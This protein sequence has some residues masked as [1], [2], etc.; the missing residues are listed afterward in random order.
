MKIELWMSIDLRNKICMS[1]SF[2]KNVNETKCER[3]VQSMPRKY[4]ESDSE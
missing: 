1:L 3:P 2:L 4:K